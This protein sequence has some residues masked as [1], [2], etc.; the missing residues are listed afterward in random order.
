METSSWDSS[1]IS[2]VLWWHSPEIGPIGPRRIREGQR[3]GRG[4]GVE[5]IEQE[6]LALSFISSCLG[7]PS[8]VWNPLRACQ[9]QNADR[10]SHTGSLHVAATKKQKAQRIFVFT[11]VVLMASCNVMHI[12]RTECTGQQA[13][14]RERSIQKLSNISPSINKTTLK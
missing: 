13:E 9:P 11:L 1:G 5:G 8:E 3:M 2:A 6:V 12:I 7:W 14:M 10:S 4:G